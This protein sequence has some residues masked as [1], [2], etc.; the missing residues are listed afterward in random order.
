MVLESV[1][2]EWPSLP[3]LRGPD[4]LSV[5][6]L[7]SVFLNGFSGI[8]PTAPVMDWRW[9]EFFKV[10][11]NVSSST[12]L[13]T[14]PSGSAL[15]GSWGES[16]SLLGEDSKF[17]GVDGSIGGGEKSLCW[18]PCSPSDVAECGEMI[19]TVLPVLDLVERGRSNVH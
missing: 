3:W 17:D 16:F 1:S 6:R 15:K 8:A 10:F 7:A 2:T 19:R 9:P 13:S 11:C 18:M 14:A 4:P 12:G 5:L